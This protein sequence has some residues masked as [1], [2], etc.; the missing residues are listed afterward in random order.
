M[1]LATMVVLA[2]ARIAT[3]RDDERGWAFLIEKLANDGVPR[4]RVLQV[5]RD[6]RVEPFDGLQFSVRPRESPAL[7]RGLHTRR[8]AAMARHCLARYEAAFDE[9]ERRFGVSSAVVAAI[10]EVESGCGAN[11]GHSRIMPALARLAMAAEPDNLQRNILRL[12][13]LTPKVPVVGLAHGRAEQLENMFYPEVRATFDIADR[14]HVDPLEIRGSGSGAFG[15]PQF[16]PQ[17]YLRFGVDGDGDGRVSLY[18]PGDA[19]PS[20][21]HYLQEYGWRGGLSQKEK[22]K[23]IWG[24]NHSDAY[25]DTVLWLADEVRSPTPEPATR[26][27]SKHGSKTKRGASSTKHGTTKPHHKTTRAQPS[28]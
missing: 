10:I 7:Y 20:C 6:D 14:M 17:S 13:L 28:A 11:T 25:I 4:D 24:Y 22:R 2:T 16:L 1:T 9:A 27:N 3:A 8:T 15:I 21:A 19:I 26:K 12:S 23:V 5:F 18:D